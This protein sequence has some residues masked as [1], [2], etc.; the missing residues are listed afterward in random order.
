M[1]NT[2]DSKY[3]TPRE[4]FRN[5]LVDQLRRELIGPD[6]PPGET[7][8]VIDES[9][10]QRYSAGILF[11]SQ[12]VNSEIEDEDNEGNN[13]PEEGEITAG[14]SPVPEVSV[15]AS[16]A[17]RPGAEKISGEYDDTITMANTYMPSAMGISFICDNIDIGLTIRP[18]VAIYKS[19]SRKENDRKF[20]VWRRNQLDLPTV[21]LSLKITDQ[22]D[23]ENRE[24]NLYKNLKI[25]TIVRSRKD[26]SR[27]VTVTLYNARKSSDGK[28]GSPSDCFYQAGFRIET[29][30][31]KSV[32]RPYQELT[33]P[34]DDPEEQG[35]RLL[36]RKRL[37]FGFGHGCAVD[38]DVRSEN[39]AWF[40]ET[41]SLPTQKIPPVDPRQTGGKE[42]SMQSLSGGSERRDSE[43]VP[44]ILNMPGT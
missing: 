10:R 25:R 28:M 4:A 26:G 39:K 22:R 13:I 20:T 6:L 14:D 18:R 2:P 8:E 5:A 34:T 43:K 37:S 19:E 44:G 32:F 21:Q 36:F 16:K 1:T 23:I 15:L 42:L 38:W 33:S 3:E 17:S 9:P 7:T 40:I 12:Q 24:F 31:K 11:P 35:L 29:D 27:L 41:D 30:E